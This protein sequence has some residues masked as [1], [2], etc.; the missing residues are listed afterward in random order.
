MMFPP[1]RADELT[2]RLTLGLPRRQEKRPTSDRSQLSAPRAPALRSAAVRNGPAGAFAAGRPLRAIVVGW[3][4]AIARPT[5]VPRGATDRIQA[6]LL[7]ARDATRLRPAHADDS[8]RPP[9]GA[10]R[11]RV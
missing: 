1:S 8:A 10:A 9:P 7:D 6:I 5:P 11:P 2:G 4:D 3:H